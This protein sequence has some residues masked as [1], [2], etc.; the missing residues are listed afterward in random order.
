MLAF[1]PRTCVACS[2]P[3]AW[4]PEAYT[5]T[6]GEYLCPGCLEGAMR[7]VPSWGLELVQG[8]ERAIVD[9]EG[10]VER[11]EAFLSLVRLHEMFC[12]RPAAIHDDGG[13]AGSFD[14]PPSL[15]PN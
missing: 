15:S 13:G 8:V 12:K 6:D 9:S 7:N 1:E 11:A 3:T 2:E 5:G 4:R 14:L 10:W